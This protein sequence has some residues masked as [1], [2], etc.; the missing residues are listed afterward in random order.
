MP[1]RDILGGDPPKFLEFYVPL[2]LMF[3]AFLLTHFQNFENLEF[4]VRHFFPKVPK[5]FSKRFWNFFN[6]IKIEKY[7]YFVYKLAQNQN[8]DQNLAKF[9]P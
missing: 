2:Q 3:S 4:Y 1:T 5:N 9:F 6:F 7:Y 8:I